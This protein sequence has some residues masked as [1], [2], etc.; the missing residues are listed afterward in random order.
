MA[1]AEVSDQIDLSTG[2]PPISRA[3][4]RHRSCL[5]RTGRQRATASPGQ[6]TYLGARVS[7]HTQYTSARHGRQ[8]KDHCGRGARFAG[9]PR[10]RDSYGLEAHRDPA[11]PLPKQSADKT[12]FPS[13]YGPC[14]FN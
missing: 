12:W 8:N 3:G 2:R 13:P 9:A 10:S 6:Q 1:S 14:R 4:G 11:H 7:Q 5:R